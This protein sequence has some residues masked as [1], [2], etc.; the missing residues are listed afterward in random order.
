M[1]I[2]VNG[3][4]RD[5]AA[6]CSLLQY[7]QSLRLATLERGVA[8]CVNGEL[9]RRAEWERLRLQPQDELEIVQAAQGG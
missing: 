9:V 3:E 1:E 8:V 7:L 5:I 2:T 4:P 6:P